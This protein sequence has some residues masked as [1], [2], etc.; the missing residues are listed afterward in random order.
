MTWTIQKVKIKNHISQSYKKQRKTKVKYLKSSASREKLTDS[1]K[2]L[3]ATDN[4]DYNNNNKFSL[5][6]AYL[7]TRMI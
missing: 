7:F 5:G 3:D 4:I 1:T 2:S 6:Q